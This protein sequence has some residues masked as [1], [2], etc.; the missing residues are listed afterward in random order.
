MIWFI[1]GIH[2]KSDDDIVDLIFNLP[3]TCTLDVADRGDQTLQTIADIF[4]IS[5]ERIRQIENYQKHEKGALGKLRGC[6]ENG[7]FGFLR[8][9]LPD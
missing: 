7:E 3:E 6:T 4:G 8:E 1:Y 9:L 5:R 2:K